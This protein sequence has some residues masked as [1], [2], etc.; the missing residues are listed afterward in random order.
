[1]L[2]ETPPSSLQRGSSGNWDPE[3]GLHRGQG[4]L[5][6]AARPLA[7]SAGRAAHARRSAACSLT[8][9]ASSRDYAD[10]APRGRRG[11]VRR[12]ADLGARPR[13]RRRRTS[14]ATSSAARRASSSTSSRTPTRSRPSS[15]SGCATADA[16]SERRLAALRPT[17]GRLF[18][19]G[20]PKQSIYRF[21]RADIAIYELVKDGPLGRPAAPSSTQN[22]RSTR[23]AARWINRAFDD[24][25]VERA[26]RAGRQH[27][28]RRAADRARRRARPP[29][30]RRRPRR[31]AR[32]QAD[33]PRTRATRSRADRRRCSR[34]AVARRAL[35]GARARRRR[36]VRPA[37][38][39]D[40]AILMPARTSL[41]ALRGGA[42]GAPACRTASRPAAAST[43]AR[44]SATRSRCCDAIDDPADE[45]AVVAALRS[46][47]FGCSDLDLL[48]VE[49]RRRALRLS[50][51]SWNGAEPAEI[52]TALAVLHDLHRAQ[53]ALSLGELVRRAFQDTGLVEAALTLPA[54]RP[55]GREPAQARRRRARVLGR[56]RRRPARVHDL[57]RAPARRG[58]RRR[59]RARRRGDRR[60]RPRA[61]D[62]RRQGARVP[63]R[64]ARRARLRRA[65][66]PRSR[67][68][69]PSSTAS[70]C[71]IGAGRARLPH[72]RLG[73]RRRAREGDAR[74]R[75]RPAHVRR[76][77][78][79]PAITWSSRSRTGRGR[80][81]GAPASR[82]ALPEPRRRRS[83]VAGPTRWTRLAD[84]ATAT[85]AH[86]DADPGR[87][88][89]RVERLRDSA[90]DWDAAVARRRPPTGA[91]IEVRSASSVKAEPRPL[92]AD[93]DSGGG[94]DTPGRHRPRAAARPRRRA[95]PH[96][97][98]RRPA[99][100]DH[101]R[102]RR[103]GDLPRARARRATPPR[104]PRWLA[105]ASPRRRCA[106]R[107]VL[108]REV[109]F[110]MPLDGG[111]V[112]V[113]RIDAVADD[114][115]V[116]DFKTDHVQDGVVL[117]GAE[118]RGQLEAYRDAVAAARGG[119]D[120]SDAWIVMA[121]TGA[122]A[123]M[124]TRTPAL[125]LS[126][127][128]SMNVKLEHH[129][130]GG[131]VRRPCC[132]ITSSSCC[133]ALAPACATGIKPRTPPTVVPHALSICSSAFSIV[134]SSR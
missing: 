118:H 70:T 129:R 17:P 14:A 59:R 22:F 25:L 55:G 96:P 90:R 65:Q 37:R 81:V 77:R 97:R 134:Q 40:C 104:S 114:G 86:A 126:T 1:M 8:P 68:P 125:S 26:R 34:R 56:R 85:S 84:V 123:R 67:S 49:A 105:A 113:G 108:H 57:A 100:R 28:A 4:H 89:P 72:A 112:L 74:R 98:A 60:P 35:A 131:A 32:G 33:A 51:A 76:V 7:G 102:R 61:H 30:G 128:R 41:G 27:A 42:A 111:D 16:R 119:E 75:A 121:R 50:R 31:A 62:P 101:A 69:T 124:L 18:V 99:R 11:R 23:A 73:R 109:P 82:V 83:R 43:P 91:G 66:R 20:D 107:R 12:P 115:T 15:S 80:H 36:G 38:W 53:R 3:R 6:R 79:V 29:V 71:T 54:R 52:A 39:R 116:V 58:G 63:D 127:S 122:A 64:R 47:A 45:I 87:M 48:R 132:S 106:T 133:A 46:L 9:S 5:P 120:E 94:A 103:R 13:A 24:V 110:V 19:V 117:D 2:F 88:R 92:V 10:D 78:P 44:R 21:R 93:A 95:A 130:V